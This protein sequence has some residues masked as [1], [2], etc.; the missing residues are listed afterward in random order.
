MF[1]NTPWP[2]AAVI[3]TVAVAATAVNP[4]VG[5]PKLISA[6]NLVAAVS[7]VTTSAATCV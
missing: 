5:V 4:C 7:T 3:V 6:A 1:K 2:A